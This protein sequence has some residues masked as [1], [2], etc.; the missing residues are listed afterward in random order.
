MTLVFMAIAATAI[1]LALHFDVTLKI[2]GSGFNGC[3]SIGDLDSVLL[4]YGVF[5]F[6]LAMLVTFG[7]FANYIDNRRRGFRDAW[8][9]GRNTLLVLVLTIVIGGGVLLVFDRLCS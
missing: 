8:I 7:E 9:N 1:Y 5:G 4:Y 3:Q 2:F 6:V